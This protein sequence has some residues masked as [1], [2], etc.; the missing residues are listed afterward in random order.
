LSQSPTA[1]G[2]NPITLLPVI[3]PTHLLTL[4]VHYAQ[5]FVESDWTPEYRLDL[6]RDTTFIRI[7]AYRSDHSQVESP[8]NAS[9]RI[10]EA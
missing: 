4:P 3:M 10:F 1:V 6:L 2:R 9:R 5:D 7:A 8:Y